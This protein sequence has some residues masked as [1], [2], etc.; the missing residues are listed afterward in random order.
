MELREREDGWCDARRREHGHHQLAKSN[1]GERESLCCLF[2]QGCE[3]SDQDQAVLHRRDQQ[4]LN[5]HPVEATPACPFVPKTTA[6]GERAFHPCH[7]ALEC[8][9]PLVRPG[10]LPTAVDQL[11]FDVTEDRSRS[12]FCRGAVG[13]YRAD[14]TCL[15]RCGVLVGITIRSIG[16]P[17]QLL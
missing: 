1:E 12:L 8:C 5:A 6:P 3:A 11:L 17:L 15:P 2:G 14:P 10:L 7:A 9:P 16:C 4:V 13:S